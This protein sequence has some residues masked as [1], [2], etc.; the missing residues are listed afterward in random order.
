MPNGGSDC[1]GTCWFNRANDGV[2]GFPV[3]EAEYRESYCEIREVPIE[4]PFYTYCANHPHRMPERDPI[5]IGPVTRN[6]SGGLNNDR[7]VWAL[8][9]DSPEIRSHLLELVQ[10]FVERPY[11]DGYPIG[12][13][14]AEVAIWQLG[15][16]RE[17]RAEENILWIADNLPEPWEGIA[18][19][20]L[21][22]IRSDG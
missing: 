12:A 16:F 18:R 11:T 21:D 3:P 10:D 5:P 20:A 9:P 17:R 8:S 7:T 4:N 19:S 2:A 14:L 15:E 22:R 1:C 13:G 6:V